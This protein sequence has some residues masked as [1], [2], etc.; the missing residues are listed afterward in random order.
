[1]FRKL[2]ISALALV[3]ACGAAFADVYTGTTAARST[4]A[5]QAGSAGVVQEL[6]VQPGSVVAEGEMIA[7]IRTVKVFA[8]QDGTVARIHGE[9][10]STAQGNVLEISP[11]SRYTVY[12]T[13]DEACENIDSKIVHCGETLYLYC[14]CNGTHQ[15][16]GRV[17]SIDGS[18]YMA[19]ATGGDFYVGET[20]YLYR[21]AAHSYRHLVG[22][23][24]VVRSDTE[25]YSC[26]GR[27]T[28]IHVSEGEY[29]ERGELLYEYIEND[30]AVAAAPA[31]GIIVSCEIAEG[32]AVADGQALAYLAPFEEICVSFRVD[33]QHAPQFAI[34][35]KVLMSYAADSE[36]AIIYGEIRDISRLPEEGGYTV[37]A[38]P[39]VP[40]ERIGMTVFVRT[41]DSM[42]K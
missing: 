9:E 21:D 17:Y 19:E 37:W 22:V 39:E 26:E 4:V 30:A 36:E 40:A 23:G 6:S 28:R 24:T 13:S 15:G 27:I 5:V 18:T 1:M 31:D 12:C 16:S 29:V 10:G 38:A 2:C 7:G 20:V 42:D 33:E 32:N 41:I 8:S 34:G 35:E 14:T 11:V 25:M 3:L